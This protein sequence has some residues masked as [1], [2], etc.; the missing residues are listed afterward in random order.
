MASAITSSDVILDGLFHDNYHYKIPIYQRHYV[1]ELENW[2]TLWTDI[3]NT[4]EKRIDG[5]PDSHFIG[6]IAKYPGPNSTALEI[7]EIVDG[8][9]RLTTFQLIF[10]AIRNLYLSDTDPAL[11]NIAKR[12]HRRLINEEHTI[13]P[14]DPDTQYILSPAG[15]DRSQ[16]LGIVDPTNSEYENGRLPANI[17]EGKCLI[18]KAY[19]HFEKMIQDYVERDQ[20]KLNALFASITE[21]FN[22]IQIDI[23]QDADPEKIF[24]SLNATGR[25]LYEFD[26]LRNDLFLRARKEHGPEKRDDFYTNDWNFEKQYWTSKRSELFLKDFLRAKLGLDYFQDQG[27]NRAPFDLY[28]E[29]LAG[30]IETEFSELKKY[31]KFQEFT[32]DPDAE[33]LRRNSEI[34]IRMQFYEDLRLKSLKPLVLFLRFGA[35]LS[36]EDFSKVCEILESYIVRS[37]L[38]RGDSQQW[39]NDIDR[40]FRNSKHEDHVESFKYFLFN[41]REYAW[42]DNTQ[43]ES[44]LEEVGAKDSD[45]IRYILYRIEI[46]M[47]EPESTMSI[48][49]KDLKT[50]EHIVSSEES[51]IIT[52]IDRVTLVD[53]LHQLGQRTNFQQ[54]ALQI[55]R[56]TANSIGNIVPF[57]STA[58][59]DWFTLPFPEKKEI[60][61]GQNLKMNEWICRQS[62]WNSDLVRERTRN[63]FNIFKSIWKYPQL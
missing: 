7:Y 26:Y 34:G 3:R 40:F 13:N 38:C 22:L 27:K 45:F 20:D 39:Y 21:D 17:E 61:K 24:A 10:C 37:M 46:D 58:P 51:T 29:Q 62:I 16:F 60:L 5:N 36:K 30:N 54:E 57:K 52:V 50:L 53:D 28:R 43:V 8:Q 48:S 31:A 47:Q 4:C 2:K 1:W 44:A 19:F 23:N 41:H 33:S 11:Q 56:K 12:A 59:A 9:Q 63:L 18:H 15:H 42:P 55:G 6:T 32:S 49:F 14:E 35:G 25:M